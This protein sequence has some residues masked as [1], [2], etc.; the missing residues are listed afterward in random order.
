MD[1]DT[2]SIKKQEDKICNTSFDKEENISNIFN[3][4]N[5]SLL[6]HKNLLSKQ[7]DEKD[8]LIDELLENKKILN[9]LQKDENNMKFMEALHDYNEIKDI[10]Q[11]I[12]GYI[13]S[14]KNCSIKQIYN[15]MNI[16]DN[17]N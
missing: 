4:T 16:S 14:I 10:A 2:K 1:D 3:P 5:A 9:Q 13:A 7:E 17:E 8:I 12:L 15:D 11:E 6:S